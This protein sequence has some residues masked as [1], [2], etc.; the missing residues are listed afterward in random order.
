MWIVLAFYWLK[1]LNLIMFLIVL[2][3]FIIASIYV[4][5]QDLIYLSVI[6]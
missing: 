2:L 1:N 5:S 3:E 6:K 4:G